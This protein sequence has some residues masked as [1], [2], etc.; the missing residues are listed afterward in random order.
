MSGYVF[1]SAPPKYDANRL[2]Q[3]QTLLPLARCTNRLSADVDV[4]R[5]LARFDFFR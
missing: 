1:S 2:I 4:D 5:L 3:R